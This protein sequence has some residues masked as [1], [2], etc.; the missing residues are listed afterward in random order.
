M[1]KSLFALSKAPNLNL[2]L[3]GGQLYW[4]FLLSKVSLANVSSSMEIYGKSFISLWS[5]RRSAKLTKWSSSIKDKYAR[6]ENLFW[7]SFLHF[8]WAKNYFFSSD[9]QVLRGTLGWLLVLV[10]ECLAVSPAHFW[11]GANV[12]KLYRVI[13]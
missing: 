3:H 11:W 1:Q 4:A 2:L 5:S 7:T 12:I 10:T 9:F 13:V 6:V 8:F